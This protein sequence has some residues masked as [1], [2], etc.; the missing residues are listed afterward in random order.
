MT[1]SQSNP[2]AKRRWTLLI[3]A[4]TALVMA[5]ATSTLA[6]HDVAEFELDKNATNDA[7]VTAL[8]SLA[9]NVSGVA[10]A[11]S[12]RVCQTGVAPATPFTIL[13]EAERMS[14]TANAAANFGGNCAGAKRSYTVTRGLDGTVRAAHQASGV[15]G[16]VSLIQSATKAG[17][18][19]NQVFAAVQADPE[20]NCSALGLVECSYVHDGIGPSTFIGGASK[21]HLPIVGWQHTSGASPDKAEILNAYAAKAVDDESGDQLLYFGMDRYAVDG[22]TD[23]GFWFFRGTVV[24]NADGTFTGEH[25]GTLNSSPADNDILALATFTQG[26]AATNIRVF[27]WV[28]SGGNESGTVSGPDA[29][30]GDCIQDPPLTDDDLCGTVNNTTIEVPWAY[31]FKGA[32]TGGWVPA[33]GMFEGGIN[34]TALGLE[35]CFSS[36]LAETRSSPEITAILK[37]FTLGAF[38]SCETDLVTTPADGEGAALEDTNENDLPD[39]EIGTGSAGVDVQDNYALDVKGITSWSGTLN[40]YLCGPIA[41]PALCETGGVL[42]DS[43]AIDQDTEAPF[44]SDSANITEAGRYCWRGFFDSATEGVPDA[45]D[46]SAGE[47]FEVLPV[48]PEISTVATAAAE[49]GGAI[50]D[51]ATLSGTAYQPGTDGAGDEN[52][53][54]TSINATMDSPASGT[55]TFSAYS[56]DACTAP[57]VYSSDVTVSGDSEEGVTEYVAS[58]GTGGAFEPSGTGFYYWIASYDGDEPNTLPDSGA[59]GDANETSEVVD[60][61]IVLDPLEATN[62]SGDEHTITATVTQI[63]GSGESAAPDG[64]LV[65]FSLLN[66]DAL[67][68]FTLDEN[69]Q[70]IDSCTTT[71]G[72]CSVTIVNGATGSVD[73]HAETTFLV[74]GVSL[75]RETDGVGNNSADANKIFVDASIAVSPESDTNNIDNEHV[76]TIVVTISPEGA[77]VT[78]LV[79]T[80][81]LTPDADEY[82]D[83]CAVEDVVVDGDTYTCTV[84]INHGSA[85]TFTLNASVSM[86]I[87]GLEVVRDTDPATTEVGAGPDGSGPATKEFVDGSLAWVKH[88]Q[89]GELLGGATFEVC[90]THWLDTTGTED[91]LVEFLDEN[92]ESAPVCASVV[93]DDGS[94]EAYAG[95]DEDPDAGEFLVSNLSLGTWTI[96]ETAAP[97]GYSFDDEYTQ[98]VQLTIASPDGS[99]ALPFVNER[100]FKLIV[101]TCNESTGELVVSSV[102]LN[103]EGKDT[104]GDVPAAWNALS[105]GDICGVTEGAVYGELD[106]GTYDPSVVIPKGPAGLGV[107]IE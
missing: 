11:T 48:Q 57:A 67:A 47:C 42:V 50:D 70:P 106:A 38:E 32:A 24:A 45:T 93:D 52:G 49:I 8:A 39:I 78:D 26:G 85:E 80:P 31:Q 90:Q 41:D 28:G 59:C 14:V 71:G 100:L 9:A 23:I 18:D 13:V 43:Q 12:I 53:D 99:A 7:N 105:E 79:I 40:T 86:K 34:L 51:T 65:E 84:T 16:L 60:A 44:T 87:E 101:I 20:T 5:L 74:S 76:F 75:T 2:R 19:W 35:G 10:S 56:D 77:D 46:A 15:T 83:T 17:P 88:D 58:A 102:T 61:Y 72:E 104:I 63:T 54:Y 107:T 95:L 3:I 69:D 27:R 30:A 4:V 98:T 81:T 68:T 21:D 103:G 82:A 92:D 96:R 6:V 33:G 36:F 55:I 89:D 91:V 37:D 97:E 29:D 64:T 22:S 1:L 25:Q 94:D 66:N 62:E 73:I